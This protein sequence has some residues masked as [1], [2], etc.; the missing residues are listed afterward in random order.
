MSVPRYARSQELGIIG[1]AIAIGIVIESER[2]GKREER[3][4]KDE[5]RGRMPAGRC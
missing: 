5:V 4:V 3:R 1:I 2:R